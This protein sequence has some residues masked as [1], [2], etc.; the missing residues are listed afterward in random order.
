MPG[1]SGISGEE[2]GTIWLVPSS[3]FSFTCPSPRYSSFPARRRAAQVVPAHPL[4]DD[5]GEKFRPDEIPHAVELAKL[6]GADVRVVAGR[7]VE[8]RGIAAAGA[9]VGVNLG[10]RPGNQLKASSLESR[11]GRGGREDI[12]A[13]RVVQFR[14]VRSAIAGDSQRRVE[15][16]RLGDHP[17]RGQRCRDGIG[18]EGIIAG[19]A[20]QRRD[21]VASRLG[22]GFDPPE[23]FRGWRFRR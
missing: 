17:I 4:D 10:E 19:G 5:L 12:V 6:R 8:D 18:E 3:L 11:L 23:E 22:I 16:N 21:V 2:S 14:R 15:T 13:G 1:R 20:P 9:G 7:T